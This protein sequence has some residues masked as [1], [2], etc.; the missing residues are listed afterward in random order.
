MNK[1]KTKFAVGAA[2]LA[3]AAAMGGLGAAS[4]ASAVTHET[5]AFMSGGGGGVSCAVQG[6]HQSQQLK[7]QGY[8]VHNFWCSGIYLFVSVSK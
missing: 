5:L 8:T 4:P 3:L 2:A 1:I 7:S 6:Y